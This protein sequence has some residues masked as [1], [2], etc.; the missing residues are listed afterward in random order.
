M[1]GDLIWHIAGKEI[2][3]EDREGIFPHLPKKIKAHD[4]GL[5]MT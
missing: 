5:V 2:K 1:V 4:Y 3:E